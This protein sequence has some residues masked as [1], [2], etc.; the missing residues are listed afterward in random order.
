MDPKNLPFVAKVEHLSPV[1]I[2]VTTH[3]GKVEIIDIS[4]DAPYVPPT[5]E[6]VLAEMERRRKRLEE[7]LLVGDC[8]FLF[9][10][11]VRELSFGRQRVAADL[12]LAVEVLSSSK[13]PAEKADLLE[14]M[15][16]LPSSTGR[17]MKVV[18]G[19]RP[20]AQLNERLRDLVRETR[21][22]PRAMHDIPAE[23]PWK[24]EE[25][26]VEEAMKRQEK[27]EPESPE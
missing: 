19:F 20:S 27:E 8:F 7:R 17:L 13:S 18:T 15:G 3:A 25:R 16:I 11:S 23:P 10:D 24:T 21:I 2:K 22:K 9:S 4:T 12:P 6:Q 26:M 5:K 1:L 14:R